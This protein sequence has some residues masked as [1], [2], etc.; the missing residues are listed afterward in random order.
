MLILSKRLHS[1]FLLRCFNDCFAIGFLYSAIYFYQ[2]RKW[3]AGSLL[4]T[5]AL[6][7]KMSILLALPGVA[8]ILLLAMG[9]ERFITQMFLIFQI[10]VCNGLRSLL[11]ERILTFSQGALRLSVYF[12]RFPGIH[13]QSF[14]P[15]TPISVRMDCELEI[16]ARR[17]FSFKV[18]CFRAPRSA[19]VDF[20]RFWN[21][22]VDQAIREITH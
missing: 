7:V 6:G 16:R 22:P 13:Y 11:L 9:R 4:F 15:L 19:C 14:R 2:K 20:G 10:Q 12:S 5:A 18:I 17:H 3:T 1:I 21:N 8:T